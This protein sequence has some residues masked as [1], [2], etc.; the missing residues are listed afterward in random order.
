M[1]D[2]FGR[3]VKSIRVSVTERCNLAC[4]YCHREGEW[5]IHREEMSPEEIERILKIARELD[6]RKVKFTGGEPLVREDFVDIVARAAKYMDKDISLTTNGTLLKNFAEDLKKV[7]VRRVNVSLDTLDRRKYERITGRDSLNDVIDGVYAAMNAGMIPVKL[8]VVV[9]RGINDDELENM[10]YFSADT[11]AILQLIELEVPLERENSEFFKKYH[12]DL[13]DFE[14]YISKMAEKV[15]YNELHRRKRYSLKI[16]DKRATV[17]FVR[18]M[19][20]TSFCMNC[21]RIR[22]TSDGKLKPC[23]LRNDNLVDLL[24]PLRKGASDDE[25]KKLFKQAILLREPYWR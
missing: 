5:H 15:E 17:E 7:G 2:R 23:L 3:P 12:V 22:L 16:N 11:G 21:T 10:I 9:L 18:S 4:F 20:N 8:N 14:R 6:I 19:H 25:L 13:S 24:T 1:L